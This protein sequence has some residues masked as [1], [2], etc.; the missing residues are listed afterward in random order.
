MMSGRKRT[1]ARQTKSTPKRAK[2]SVPKDHFAGSDTDREKRQLTLPCSDP[3]PPT[4]YYYG[5]SFDAA[6]AYF[7]QDQAMLP[8]NFVGTL[9][10][11][12][13]H[14]VKRVAE[15]L[16]HNGGGFAVFGRSLATTLN[17]PSS[18]PPDMLQ[19]DVIIITRKCL[20]IFISFASE[21][22][23]C[24]EQYNAELARQKL[25]QYRS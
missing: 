22:F 11:E 13:P 9:K 6:H 2:K 4:T 1:G 21:A 5:D 23:G 16:A 24:I 20:P 10:K 8:L 7:S 15:L 12:H 19:C 25:S 14:V 18:K 3:F 17:L